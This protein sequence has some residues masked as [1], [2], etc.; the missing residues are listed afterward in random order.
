MD[1]LKKENIDIVGGLNFPD[2]FLLT[3]EIILNVK[4]EWYF[5][6]AFFQDHDM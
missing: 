3:K 5:A 6:G 2:E 4:D 1:Y